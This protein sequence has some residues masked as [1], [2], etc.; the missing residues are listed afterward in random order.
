VLQPAFPTREG[1]PPRR[2]PQC[3]CRSTV[4]HLSSSAPLRLCATTALTGAL[5]KSPKAAPPRRP[6]QCRCRSTAFHL[7]RS[8]PPRLCASQ[9]T[10]WR[11]NPTREGRPPRRPPQCQQLSGLLSPPSGFSPAAAEPAH[12]API[13][14][15]G[16]T[17]FHLS[18]S[19][20]LRL[21]ASQGTLWRIS[22]A[23]GT[24]S[25][26]SASIPA[27]RSNFQVCSLLPR[28]S[29][30]QPQSPPTVASIV[31]S[32]STVFHLSSSAPLRDHC[33]NWRTTQVPEGSA[34]ASSESSAAPV[35]SEQ[36][37][38]QHRLFH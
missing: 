4:F 13:V 34:S 19:A 26:S 14:R 21:C 18:S 33:T 5:P 38:P 28:V 2:P 20:P 31:R 1:R 29:A 8:A 7:S 30:P 15:S 36:L 22:A 32:G 6:P 10:L 24:T 11:I 12:R 27:P 16:S 17:V 23:G 9:G 37:Q 3:R 25:A 35:S